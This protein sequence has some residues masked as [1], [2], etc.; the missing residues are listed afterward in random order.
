[1][2]NE[3]LGDFLK[4]FGWLKINPRSQG[5]GFLLNA[6]RATFDS[7][8]NPPTFCVDPYE[9]IQPINCGGS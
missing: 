2:L 9:A 5:G 6:L 7:H 8:P 4:L 3:K 1:L